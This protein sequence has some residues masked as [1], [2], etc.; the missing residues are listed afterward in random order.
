MLPQFNTHILN[1]AKGVVVGERCGTNLQRIEHFL[2]SYV[3]GSCAY[4]S[5]C[6]G[7][8]LVDCKV[9]AL[10]ALSEL[11]TGATNVG[12][13]EV[14]ARTIASFAAFLL[15]ALL[16]GCAVVY[17]FAPIE[18]WVVDAESGEPIGDVVVIA[19]WELVKGGLDGPRYVGQLDVRE[20]V[21]DKDGRFYFEAFTKSDSSG[22]ELRESDPQVIVFK[23]GY[24]YQV[25]TNQYID[26][27]AGMRLHTRVAAVHG[28]KVHLIRSS[29][30]RKS[31]D[32]AYFGLNTRIEKVIRDCHWSRI[33]NALRVMDA[34]DTKMRSN[35]IATG[36]LSRQYL[37]SFESKCGSVKEVYGK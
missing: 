15:A 10:G 37:E 21:T 24:E 9:C 8:V 3:F 34:E 12:G 19:N 1:I 30:S 26:G 32:G 11:Q 16:S 20:T 14:R 33:A 17:R 2:E 6:P 18:A 7:T 28:R 35:L 25:F 27:G 13:Y 29:V 23:P 4:A 36:L 22:A 5:T 31:I